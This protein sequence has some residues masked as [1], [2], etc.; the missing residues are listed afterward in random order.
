MYGEADTDLQELQASMEQLLREPPSEE[1][2][3][4]EEATLKAEHLAN[5]TEMDEDDNNPTSESAINE[6]W[7]SGMLLFQLMV[8]LQLLE[9]YL[10]Q[11][12]KLAASTTSTAQ[13]PT[14]KIAY[15]F[16]ISLLYL[17]CICQTCYIPALYSM[18]TN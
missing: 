8:V 4:E 16:M 11:E 6:E 15:Q 18:K 1:F 17:C 9:I 10:E 14:T 5:D 3:E 7:H 2:S 13:M 12:P